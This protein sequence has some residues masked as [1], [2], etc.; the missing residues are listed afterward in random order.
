MAIDQQQGSRFL[1]LCPKLAEVCSDQLH[2]G[3]LQQS[4][5]LRCQPN[6][7][8]SWVFQIRTNSPFQTFLEEPNGQKKTYDLHGKLSEAS[9]GTKSGRPNKSLPG[10]LKGFGILDHHGARLALL[11]VLQGKSMPTQL[12]R[13]RLPKM[14]AQRDG[15]DRS[16]SGE[17]LR[18]MTQL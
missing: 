15:L 8:R 11:H 16:F 6:Q 7:G 18:S 12:N 9:L 13:E 17:S 14:S 4:Q 5:N 3:I 1:P 2:P 10:F